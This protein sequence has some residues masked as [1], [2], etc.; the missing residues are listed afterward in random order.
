MDR[1]SGEELLLRRRSSR[2][3][4][5]MTGRQATAMGASINDDDGDTGREEATAMVTG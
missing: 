4:M 3:S 2:L 5:A 1:P